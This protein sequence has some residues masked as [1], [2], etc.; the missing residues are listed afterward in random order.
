M[1]RVYEVDPAVIRRTQEWLLARQGIDGAWQPDRQSLND[2][3]YRNDFHGKL[4]ATA[5]LA[6]ALAESGYRGP[7]LD[8]AMSFLASRS[9]E[10][11]GAYLPALIANTLL[12]GGRDG[13][14]ATVLDRLEKAAAR[15]GEKVRF[16]AGAQTAMYASG[17]S[18][19]AETTALAALALARSGRAALVGPALDWL[20]S[21]RDPNGAWGS[22]QATVLVL[23]TLLSAQATG[24]DPRA[25]GE[26]RVSVDGESAAKVAL[27]PETSDLVQTVDLTRHAK[28]GKP[29]AVEALDGRHRPRPFPAG[30]EGL[31][32]QAEPGGGAQ[33]QGGLRPRDA[34][35]RRHD[36]FEGD[37]HL[38][39][40]GT[41]GDGDAGA[42]C[43]AGLR[44]RHR[45]G[46]RARR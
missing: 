26:V 22:T 43:A 30:H 28:P 39:P 18:A 41:V 42:G 40:V 36:H 37:S 24:L 2:G 34:G 17:S 35:A 45:L 6:W 4:G 13:D 15:D 25:T 33:L 10:A 3:L 1:A 29:L 21:A 20:L 31:G 23:R 19:D 16:P 27:T 38:E 5:Y 46:G 8:N 14:A 9:R 32:A 12:L 7:A 11:E 44:G